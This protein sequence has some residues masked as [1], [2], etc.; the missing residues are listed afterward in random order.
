MNIQCVLCDICILES[1]N[2]YHC[3]RSTK[4]GTEAI[5]LSNN[6]PFNVELTDDNS[7][8]CKSCLRLLKKWTGLKKQLADTEMKIGFHRRSNPLKKRILS[9]SDEWLTLEPQL[10]HLPQAQST[11]SKRVISSH[12]QSE[13]VGIIPA[14]DTRMSAEATVTRKP[15]DVLTSLYQRPTSVSSINHEQR[16]SCKVR[17]F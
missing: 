8:I 6:L 13:S 17:V 12:A 3:A 14:T 15:K 4:T 9:C 10:L 2:R 7:Y 5:Q 11:P 1:S 16:S